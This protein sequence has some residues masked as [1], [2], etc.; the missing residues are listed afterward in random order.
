[1]QLV[2]KESFSEEQKVVMDVAKI[3]I[4]YDYLHQNAFTEYDYTCPL[5]KSIDMLKCIITF[6]DA[7]QKAIAESPAEKKVTWAYLK[8]TMGGVMQ[9]VIDAKFLNAK[10]PPPR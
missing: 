5:P 6:Y 4:W 9:K 8:T 3:I 2:G 7:C 1:V 10:T